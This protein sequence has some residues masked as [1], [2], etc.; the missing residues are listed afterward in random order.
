MRD[1]TSQRGV[2]SGD[3]KSEA[4]LKTMQAA[5]GVHGGASPIASTHSN[6]YIR[7][8]KPPQT[9]E[10]LKILLR[11]VLE[12]DDAHASKRS[13]TK[14]V[15]KTDAEIAQLRKLFL[16]YLKEEQRQHN[17]QKASTTGMTKEHLSSS[18]KG[19]KD[20]LHVLS[21][22]HL[23]AR[24]F[25]VMSETDLAQLQRLFLA[26]LHDLAAQ[27]RAAWEREKG[28]HNSSVKN[29]YGK[30][31]VHPTSQS[32]ALNSQLERTARS[33]GV[34]SHA[35]RVSK[36]SVDEA[37]DE[38]FWK[39]E[40]GTLGQRLTGAAAEGAATSLMGTAT[41]LVLRGEEGQIQSR[42]VQ[43]EA[44]ANRRGY[45]LDR[46]GSGAASGALLGTTNLVLRDTSDDTLT[47]RSAGADH[48]AQEQNGERFILH[49]DI[50][51]EK[52]KS[53]GIGH[54]LTN[55][56]HSAADGV[57]SSVAGGLT[58]VLFRRDDSEPETRSVPM[59]REDLRQSHPYGT[60]ASLPLEFSKLPL[61]SEEGLSRVH[62][63][64]RENSGGPAQVRSSAYEDSLDQQKRGLF[65]LWL[66]KEAAKHMMRRG[67]DIRSPYVA[68]G[69]Q[70]PALRG[71]PSSAQP[72]GIL[73]HLATDAAE[74]AAKEG[75]SGFSTFSLRDALAKAEQPLHAREDG[76]H[77]HA[78][79]SAPP[80]PA[81]ED[82]DNPAKAKLGTFGHDLFKSAASALTNGV[83][84]QVLGN[85]GSS[86]GLSR[87][88]AAQLLT[89][90]EDAAVTPGTSPVAKVLG[91][92]GHDLFKSAANSLTHGAMFQVMGNI[93]NSA[94]F[95]RRDQLEAKDYESNQERS[96]PA[97]RDHAADS[98][99]LGHNS[100]L[101]ERADDSEI[102]ERGP[103]GLGMTLLKDAGEEA[104]KGVWSNGIMHIGKWVTPDNWGKFNGAAASAEKSKRDPSIE[105]HAAHLVERF[106]A[107]GATPDLRGDL[108]RIDVNTKDFAGVKRSELPDA[109]LLSKRSI[110]QDLES[111]NHV[112]DSIGE[113]FGRFLG[114]FIR[115][116]A[117]TH[118]TSE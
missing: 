43:A 69:S 14:T 106:I 102:F 30:T 109:D 19:P 63:L 32:A 89:T 83:A 23:S 57:V 90:R 67:E 36:R 79:P 110:D 118:E 59:E 44:D 25:A 40:P 113:G 10:G 103:P 7:D 104:V 27:N 100:L 1:E 41:G 62:L 53:R 87:R 112:S 82:H 97:V 116:D 108:S 99:L 28:H 88:D 65:T 21:R 114:L 64:R 72:R 61:G 17:R 78:P 66:T 91:N 75:A 39:P 94:G 86:A 46:I 51:D 18:V 76:N 107:A 29:G 60:A 35:G 71:A 3:A 15:K 74:V 52:L 2:D 45:L 93:G 11:D 8:G 12:Y 49:S 42:A 68:A 34:E 101:H 117:A 115:D 47:P 33:T 31:D 20:F 24:H 85:I 111:R 95:S 26:F 80:A 38:R 13:S 96:E 16:E 105:E 22:P 73:T 70:N 98:G 77:P 56:G 55:M 6:V 50:E 5:S 37:L 84:Y 54:F 48:A 4:Y 58:G 9:S 81:T 92:F